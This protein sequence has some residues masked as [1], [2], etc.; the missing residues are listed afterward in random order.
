MYP[1]TTREPESMPERWIVRAV[2]TTRR[3]APA[4]LVMGERADVDDILDH[5]DTHIVCRS[6]DAVY[7]CD[8]VEELRE[9]IRRA[10]DACGV[11]VVFVRVTSLVFVNITTTGVEDV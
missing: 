3:G 11:D 9:E 6:G 4:L 8:S 5:L 7:G 10:S 1:A 2:P